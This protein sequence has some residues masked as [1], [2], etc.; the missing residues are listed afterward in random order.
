MKFVLVLPQFR[1]DRQADFGGPA[2]QARLATAAEAAG[3]DAVSCSDHVA[4]ESEWERTGGHHDLDPLTTLAFLAARTTT[5]RLLTYVLV[6]PFRPPLVA[7]KSL[8]T[9]DVLSE[10]RLVVGIGAGYHEPEFAA[11]GLD[12]ADHD[13]ATTAALETITRLWAED[14]FEVDGQRVR[15]LPRPVQS[16]RPPIWAG[17]NSRR[18][19]ERAARLADAWM[20]FFNTPTTVPSLHTPL[21]ASVDDLRARLP[22]LEDAAAA[23]GRPVPGIIGPTMLVSVGTGEPGRT[24]R[25][26]LS[27]DAEVEDHL[28]ALADL[29][30]TTTTVRFTGK[31][32]DAYVEQLSQFGATYAAP[33]VP[34]PAGA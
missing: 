12:F 27:T 23:A 14:G 5:I 33:A 20:P 11:L 31:T 16:P 30:V 34:T 2:G 19:I 4:I 25:A 26:P 21:I 24:T 3:F 32:V 7:A 13:R 29:G 22:I 28:G 17:G 18:A 9:I 6:L 15:Q 8:A 10:G 1:V